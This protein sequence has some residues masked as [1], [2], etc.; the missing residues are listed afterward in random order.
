VHVRVRV[1]G[2]ETIDSTDR[3]SN[4]ILISTEYMWLRCSPKLGK[5]KIEN[6]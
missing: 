2:G 1:G 5:H 3:T 4:V 6:F